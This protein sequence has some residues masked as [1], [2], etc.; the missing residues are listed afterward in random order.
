[1]QKTFIS[2]KATVS[3]IASLKIIYEM[4]GDAQ[5]KKAVAMTSRDRPEL[6]SPISNMLKQIVGVDGR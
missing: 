1:V 2:S 5:K 6:P 4:K 3:T